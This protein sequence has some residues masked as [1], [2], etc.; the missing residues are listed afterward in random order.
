M[1]QQQ[2]PGYEQVSFSVDLVEASLRE[3]DLLSEV[4]RHAVLLTPGGAAVRRAIRRYEQCWLPLAARQP[5][6]E[7]LAP[8]L[9]V[10]WV[11]HCHMLAPYSYESDVTRLV[12]TV[13]S[14]RLMTRAEL[15][16]ARARTKSLWTAAYPHEPYDVDLTASSA[17]DSTA[18]ADATTNYTS[19]CGYDLEA[20]VGRQ[21]KF[22]YQVRLYLLTFK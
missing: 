3:L 4:D 8:A 19:L 21:A 18:A 9:D 11:W 10:H 2:Q 14:H 20:A 16:K 13:V 6:S 7:S 22:Y 17:N 12:G 5:S 15:D 1:S